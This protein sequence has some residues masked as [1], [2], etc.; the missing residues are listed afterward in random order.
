MAAAMTSHPA[1]I[2]DSAPSH[3]ARLRAFLA[4]AGGQFLR[5]A[6][7]GFGIT[8]LSNLIYW[9]LATPYRWPEQLAN[10]AGYVAAVT[11]GYVLHSRFSFRG[12][13]SRDNAVRTTVRFFVASLISLGINSGWIWL[14]TDL[15][16][17]PTW[18]P[19]VPMMVVT[20]VA[21]FWLNRLWVFE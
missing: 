10:L 5:Y 9:V 19:I 13:G 21:M 8:A 1:P 11:S 3:R 4:G 2:V 7:T 17:G 18:W 16:A 12:H 15:L 20:P 14:L 6:I